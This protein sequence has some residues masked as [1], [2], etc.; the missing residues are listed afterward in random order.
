MW[1]INLISARKLKADLDEKIEKLAE[2]SEATSSTSSG[3]KVTV[4]IPTQTKMHNFYANLNK[5][6][7]KPVALSLIKPYSS[8][9][10]SQ[11]RG[12]PTIPDL[13][14]DENLNMSYIDLLK[15]CF[16]VEFS[17]SSE[18]ILQ[19]EK[20]TQNQANGSAFFRH[21]AG[22]IA[23]SVSGAVCRTNPAQ[24]S[25]TRVSLDSCNSRLSGILL[26]LWTGMW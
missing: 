4:Q 12:I 22:R 17:L 26:M 20:D 6:R 1:F 3:R 24:R 21:R 23:A 15:K 9:F 25:Q 10:L 14:E 11:S 7:I 19:I 18:E 5:S 8:Q 16:S 2:N 13:F